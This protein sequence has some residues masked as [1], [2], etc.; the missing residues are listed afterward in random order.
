MSGPLRCVSHGRAL[1]KSRTSRRG[2]V[3]EQ[4]GGEET[5]RDVFLGL[6]QGAVRPAHDVVRLEGESGL[7]FSQVERLSNRPSELAA[8]DGL[9]GAAESDL[10]MSMST[11]E[12][13]Y[14]VGECVAFQT[15]EGPAMREGS[16]VIEAMD[17]NKAGKIVYTVAVPRLYEDEPWELL[18]ITEDEVLGWA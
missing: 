13:A 18:T 4:A 9:S 2:E 14:K 15:D 17:I 10:V 6:S 12:H 16:G 11:R 8:W 5:R 3:S 7:G 1:K